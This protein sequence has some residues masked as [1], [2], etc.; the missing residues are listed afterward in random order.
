MSREGKGKGLDLGKK[1]WGMLVY[2]SVPSAGL[3]WERADR[4]I[5]GPSRIQNYLLVANFINSTKLRYPLL[6]GLTAAQLVWHRQA[7][8][9]L[10]NLHVT[11]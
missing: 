9:N 5:Q 11:H 7:P 4:I 8:M 3:A 10:R 2:H 6:F 1:S